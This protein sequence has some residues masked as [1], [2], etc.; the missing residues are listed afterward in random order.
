MIEDEEN[1]IDLFGEHWNGEGELTPSGLRMHYL[2]GHRNRKR[3]EG[4]IS[5]SPNAQELLVYSTSV[6][7][8]IMSVYAHLQGMFPSQTGKILTEA[9]LERA[10][11][12]YYNESQYLTEEIASLGFS[13]LKNSISLF[14]VHIFDDNDRELKL[15]ENGVCPG[16]QKYKDKH[17]ESKEGQNHLKQMSNLINNTYGKE[18]F[19]YFNLTDPNYYYDRKSVYVL[20]DTFIS[21]YFDKR[22]LTNFTQTGINLEQFYADVEKVVDSDLFDLEFKTEN[23][24]IVYVGMSPTFRRILDW[25]DKRISLDRAG[26]TDLIERTSPK[27]VIYSGHDTTVGLMSLFVEKVFGFKLIPPV[28]AANQYFELYKDEKNVYYVRYIF[29][30]DEVFSMAYN[31][32]K[33]KTEKVLWTKE[34]INE[35]CDEVNN[36][37]WKI[38][39]FI[40]CGIVLALIVVI[41]YLKKKLK[42]TY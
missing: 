4:F 21:D 18:L 39:T 35:F 26:K 33:Q 7:R 41:I 31:M 38:M 8:T 17:Y 12:L 40:M 23:D 37:S 1:N 22:A 16:I 5:S 32:F 30:D 10:N 13:S 6:N 25:M 19:K 15:N 9:Q 20:A 24:V 34:Q 28:F 29:N 27:M 2:L 11:D 42:E 14:P 36:Y 3:Y